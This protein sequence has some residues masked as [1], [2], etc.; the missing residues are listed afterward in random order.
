MNLLILSSL[1]GNEETNLSFLFFLLLYLNLNEEIMCIGLLNRYY[2]VSKYIWFM[3]FVHCYFI[4]VVAFLSL[5]L[6]SLS[7][8]LLG[9]PS[10]DTLAEILQALLFLISQNFGILNVIISGKGNTNLS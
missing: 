8:I 6:S 2:H 10:L 3:A 1:L 4:V 5:I 7:S 9:I